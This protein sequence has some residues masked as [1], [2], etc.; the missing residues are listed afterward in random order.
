MSLTRASQSAIAQAFSRIAIHNEMVR[1]N[2]RK[3]TQTLWLGAGVGFVAPIAVYVTLQG[4]ALVVTFALLGSVASLLRLR[5]VQLSNELFSVLSYRVPPVMLKKPVYE[6]L[7]ETL[8]ADETPERIVGE[9]VIRA[10]R[11]LE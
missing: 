7:V 10:L 2:Q 9:C 8:S 4:Q 11:D 6:Q 1:R 5:Y 3:L